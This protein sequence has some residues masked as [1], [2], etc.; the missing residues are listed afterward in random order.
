MKK[1]LINISWLITMIVTTTSCNSFL[2]ENPKTFLSPKYYFKSASQVEAAVNGL[3][4]FIGNMFNGDVEVGTQ[5]YIFMEYLPGYGIRPLAAGTTDISQAMNL[6]VAENNN[7]IEKIWET[8]YKAIENCNGVIA[9]IESMDTTLMNKASRNKLLGEAYFLRAHNYFNLVRLYGKVPLHI[10]VTTDLSDVQIPLSSVE[11]IFTLIEGDLVKANGLMAATSMASADGRVNLG[12]VKS[13]LAKVYLTMAG[14]PLQKGTEYY[15]KAYTEAMGVYSSGSFS[16]AGTYK[17]LRES[18]N[19]NTGEY[20]WM[21]QREANEAGSPVHTN[22]LPYPVPAKPTS[23]NSAFGGALAPSQAF[24]DS[25]EDYDLRI[26][27]KAFFYTEGDAQD[28]SGAVPLGAPYIYKFWD[29]DAAKTGKS[30]VNYP[31]IRYADVLLMMAEAKANVDG[32]TTS[33]ADA[34]DAY[35]KVVKRARPDEIKPSQ[36]AVND[37]LKE[38]FWELCFEN[39]TWYDMLRTR[40][41]LNVV[42]RQIVNLI[43]YQAPGHTVGQVFKESDLLFP[44]PLRERRLNPNLVRD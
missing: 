19:S 35:Y 28:G 33:D 24:Y 18:A 31:L 34:I 8:A 40:K 11:D 44:Y 15:Q 39:Q 13:L 6:T 16:L 10:T 26:A 2:E 5:T 23:A 36:I 27:E 9:G 20:I 42:S 1:R 37:V 7:R 30:G 4:T 29:S 43:G 12:A 22:M 32:G 21:V 3:Y 14:Y 38:R 17:E 25:Y 41:A